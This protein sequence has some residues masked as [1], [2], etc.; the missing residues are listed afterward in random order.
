MKIL[1]VTNYQSIAQCS[2]GFISDYLNDLTFHGFYEL[3][4]KGM[5]EEIVDS[6]PI[7][8]L[9]K[10]YESKIPKQNLWGGMT[11][12]WLINK[13]EANRQNIIQKISDKY[14]DLIVYGS[15]R[16]C[17]DYYDLVKSVYDPKKVILL[18]GNDDCNIHSIST[19]GHFY[20]KRELYDVY[21]N[22]LQISFSYPAEKIASVNKTKSQDYGTVIPGDKSTYVFKTEKDYYA[23]YNKSYYGVTTKKA[24]WDCMRHYEILG[25]YCMP[26]FVDI[27]SCPAHTLVSLP[28]HLIK[29][30]N[31]LIEKEFD[32]TQYYDIL[33][34]SFDWLKTHCTTESVAKYI[35]EKTT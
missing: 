10:E 9:Y 6:T 5:I 31:T 13:D 20:F 28:K 33:D 1:Y 19:H 35:L 7:V 22:V 24:G 14:F 21:D 16:R 12:F 30:S 11:A 8:S 26:Y 25:N 4:R 3:H 2:G 27:D 29:K 18:D 32:I 17:T 34:A 15:V 23:D